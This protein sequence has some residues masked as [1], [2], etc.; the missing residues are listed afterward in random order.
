MLAA[1]RIRGMAA[2]RGEVVD[3]LNMLGMRKPNTMVILPRSDSIIGMLKKVESMIT[4]GDID[5]DVLD[6]L[7]GKTLLHLKPPEKGFK[8]V[9]KPYP[10]GATG[11]RGKE[12]SELIKRMMRF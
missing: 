6:K 4:W 8:S 1:I 11:Y 7:Q 10:K 2:K 9:K 3:T 12:I 5:K